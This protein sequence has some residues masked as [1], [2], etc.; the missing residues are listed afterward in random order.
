MGRHHR[1][2]GVGTV[3]AAPVG[4]G[5]G[6]GSFRP[7]VAEG[8]ILLRGSHQGLPLWLAELACFQGQGQMAQVQ[9]GSLRRGWQRH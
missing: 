2:M 7:V 1:Q 4:E 3:P 9:W 8:G 6:P 5:Q